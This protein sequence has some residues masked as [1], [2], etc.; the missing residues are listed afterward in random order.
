LQI[1]GIE[2]IPQKKSS[3]SEIL[4]VTGIANPYPLENHLKRK[5]TRVSTLV[6]KDHHQYTVKDIDKILVI[7]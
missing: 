6:F 5:T 3:Y 4:L 2:F 7:K 1:P